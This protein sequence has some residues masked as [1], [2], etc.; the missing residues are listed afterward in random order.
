MLI[1][2]SLSSETKGTKLP[3]R[4]EGGVVGG[5]IIENQTFNMPKAKNTITDGKIIFKN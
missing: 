1:R 2:E 5:E 3:R 4:G